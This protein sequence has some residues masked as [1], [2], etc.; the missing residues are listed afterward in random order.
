MCSEIVIYVYSRRFI[1]KTAQAITGLPSQANLRIHFFMLSTFSPLSALKNN[2][3]GPV[4]SRP[5]TDRVLASRSSDVMP[6][7]W[8]PGPPGES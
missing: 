1:I 6:V 4:R 5:P 8:W 3:G 2:V 7:C